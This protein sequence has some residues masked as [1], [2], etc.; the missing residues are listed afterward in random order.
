MACQFKTA[1][2]GIQED[3]DVHKMLDSVRTMTEEMQQ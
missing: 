3:F 1:V 2:Y